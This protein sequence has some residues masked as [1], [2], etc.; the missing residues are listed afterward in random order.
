MFQSA[1]FVARQI[2]AKVML[3]LRAKP[4][5]PPPPYA[6]HTIAP[7]YAKRQVVTGLVHCQQL[8]WR[9]G[10]YGIAKMQRV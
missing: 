1:K 3:A 2:S 10:A 5:V 7:F 6:N 8:N 9:M 4:C